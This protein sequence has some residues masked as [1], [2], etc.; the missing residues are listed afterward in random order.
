MQEAGWQ[1][2]P[3]KTSVILSSTLSI[4]EPPPSEEATYRRGI[5]HGRSQRATR[6]KSMPLTRSTLENPLFR[7]AENG[8]SR[9][10]R[11]ESAGALGGPR[12]GGPRRRRFWGSTNTKGPPSAVPPGGGPA[13]APHSAQDDK[14]L[15]GTRP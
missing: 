8:Q 15:K 1:K 13:G 7:R 12:P 14:P 5:Y 6:I 4:F 11:S 9:A 2:H 3:L 10:E